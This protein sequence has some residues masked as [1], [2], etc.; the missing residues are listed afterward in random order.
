MTKGTDLSQVNLEL[1]ITAALIEARGL[2]AFEEARILTLAEID[3]CG[4][5]HYLVPAAATAWQGMKAAASQD[6][7]P[8][9]IVSA[10]RTVDRQIEII[11]RKLRAGVAIEHILA[12]SAPP[13]YSEH[14]TGRAV[15]ITSSDSP[16]LALEFERTPAFAWLC[17][18]AVEFGFT[19]S[20]PLDNRFGFQY[21]PWHWCFS[22]TT[23]SV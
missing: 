17:D 4:R 9:C 12:W 7:V 23:L 21:E 6:G 20:Y 16:P 5:A 2:S 13:G 3:A 11:R 19:L 22:A 8:L 18:H 15:D 1:G 10:F 14:H